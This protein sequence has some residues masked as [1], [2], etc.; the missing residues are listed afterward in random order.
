[1]S[2]VSMKI[3][4]LALLRGMSAILALILPSLIT[5]QIEESTNIPTTR[6][7]T[8]TD[9]RHYTN[10]TLPLDLSATKIAAYVPNGS[11][12]YNIVSGS[13]TS[14]GTF[15]IPNVPS[16]YYLL[17]LGT[18]FLITNNSVVDEDSAYGYRSNGVLA[19]PNTELTFDLANL[20][21]WQSNDVF[22]MVCPNNDAYAEFYGTVGATDFA[23][24]FPYGQ[25]ISENLSNASQGDRYAI[26]QLSTQNVGGYPF[27][28]LSRSFFPPKFT[29]AQGSDVPVNGTLTTVPQ[30]HEFEANINGA[31]L[32]AQVLAANPK[33]TLVGTDIYLDPY[34]GS[35]AKWAGTATPD[36]VGY[37]L[38]WF[39]SVP[40]I[41]TNSDLG[42][43]V[44]GNP[45]PA[46]W[47]LI[48]GYAWLGETSYVAP[49]A[50]NGVNLLTLVEGST[51]TLPTSTSPM[52]PMIGV[53]TNPTIDGQTFFPDQVGVGITPTLKWVPPS[54]GKA[55]FYVVGIYELSNQAGGTAE[56]ALYTVR[57]QSTALKIPQG[58]MSVGKGY[59]FTITSWYVPGL[60]FAKTPFMSGPV[61]AFTDVISGLIQP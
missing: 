15:T 53:V 26:L 41:T 22:E 45:F 28:G 60:N 5:A 27:I 43:V 46:T 9:I 12:G 51:T 30:T 7:V 61:A 39:S 3:E 52:K 16:G 38:S 58:I 14:A 24:T 17:Q 55:T 49:G 25:F 2:T 18:S 33:A 48:A 23:G 54:I 31:D 6:T 37:S 56:T 21:S 11:G 44:Y 42:R 32:T 50:T 19:N 10:G 13:G 34:P 1:M 35:L 4:V 59:V 47:P 20:E 8:G 57:T 29:Q 40:N 36:L